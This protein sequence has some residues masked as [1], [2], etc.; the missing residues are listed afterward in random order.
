L[1]GI[2]G[3]LIV[4]HFLWV[5]NNRLFDLPIN[6]IQPPLFSK[7]IPILGQIVLYI[8]FSRI[9]GSEA[10]KTIFYLLETQRGVLLDENEGSSV[11]G[12]D[13]AFF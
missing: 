8:G 1:Q 3:R 13:R 5:K 10:F 11:L 12:V 7:S 4:C 6:L 2:L 9:L